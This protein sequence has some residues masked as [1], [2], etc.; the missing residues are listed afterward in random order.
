MTTEDQSSPTEELS[1][2]TTAQADSSDVEPQ[3]AEQ[4][5]GESPEG[6]EKRKLNLDVTIDTV[7]P[8]KK[9]IEVTIPR[10]DIEV[11]YSEAFDELVENATVPGFR[12]GHAPRK[13]IERRFRKEVAD[14]VKGSLIMAS[15]EQISEENDLSVISEPDLDPT[16]IELPNEGPMVYE[17]D[18]EVRPEFDLPD[19]KGLTVKRP[20]RDL[21]D[22]DVE[23]HMSRFLAQ[24][25]K[26]VPKDGPADPED[27]IAVDLS[28]YHDDKLI[29]EAKE[30]VLQLRPT[31]RFLDGTI[32]G[33][34]KLMQ[35]AVAGESRETT[36][37]I[38]PLAASPLRG[39][40]VRAVFNVK[41]IKR[42]ELPK[43]TGEFLD[44]LGFDAEE[45]LRDAVRS[46]LEQRLEYEQR[47]SARQQ[48]LELIA[49]SADW[50]LPEDLL[51]R[52]AN[53]TLRRQM[54]EM[55]RSGYTDQEIRAREAQLQQNS[56]AST[57]QSLKE[58]F[59]LERIAEE[60]EIEVEPKDID[61]EITALAS[62]TSESVRRIRSRL[63]K[64]NMMDGLATQI[65]ERKALDRVLEYAT[66]EDVPY[67]EEED[68]GQVEALDQAAAGKEQEQD[69]PASPEQPSDTQDD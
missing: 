22:E 52:Q 27:H 7:G 8:C 59:V 53:S 35:G 46:S 48:V 55:R 62:R 28:F 38:S 37:T 66:F 9:H 13:L 42:M 57:S 56:L 54:L 23:K 50:E 44:N 5:A 14:Q 40:D 1:K 41:E 64:E 15:L 69:E 67:E 60:E 4:P 19:Y 34:D 32:E 3:D 39:S 63:T 51:R 11:Q 30:Q 49:G 18:V 36:L 26:L 25:G 43:L 20:V 45:D 21:G 68:A 12:P 65:L 17:F 29:N 24:F 47:R 10:E 2:T 31:L 58:L 6:D 33:F 61:A 16:A